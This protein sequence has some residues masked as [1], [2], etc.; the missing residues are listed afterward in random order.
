[1][2]SE[3]REGGKAEG[4]KHCLPSSV[5]FDLKLKANQDSNGT[6]NLTFKPTEAERFVIWLGLVLSIDWVLCRWFRYTVL[7]QKEMPK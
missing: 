5:S 1:M 3:Q 6:G 7:K 2:I 4:R